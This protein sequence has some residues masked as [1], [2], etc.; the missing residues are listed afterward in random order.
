MGFEWVGGWVGLDRGK[1][2]VAE[3][4]RDYGACLFLEI[5]SQQVRPPTHPPTY[6]P[7]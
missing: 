7:L 6:P 3:M 5:D 2:E 4:L 1:E